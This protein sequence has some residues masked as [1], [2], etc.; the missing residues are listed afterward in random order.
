[1]KS[2]PSVG[3]IWGLTFVE[4]KELRVAQGG[5]ERKGRAAGWGGGVGGAERQTDRAG[6][7][8]GCGGL[9]WVRR[10]TVRS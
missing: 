5:E 2:A 1:V 10:I 9:G 8:G 3:P 6:G 7:V 4:L